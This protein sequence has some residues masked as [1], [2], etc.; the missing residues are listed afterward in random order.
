MYVSG[1]SVWDIACR[2]HVLQFRRWNLGCRGLDVKFGASARVEGFGFVGV[3]FKELGLGILVFRL[4][5][6]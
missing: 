3:E 6:F 5:E 1:I 4:E 2:I